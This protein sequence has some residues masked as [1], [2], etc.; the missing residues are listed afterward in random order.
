MCLILW[1]P[2][3]SEKRDVGG[4]EEMLAGQLVEHPLRSRGREDGMK[5][6]GKG[7]SEWVNFWNVNK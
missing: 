7:D 5:N 6:S 4:D 3:A 1:K 2:D